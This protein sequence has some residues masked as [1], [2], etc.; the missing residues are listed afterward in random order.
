MVFHRW[1]KVLLWNTVF[2]FYQT[3]T[4]NSSQKLYFALFQQ[5]FSLSICDFATYSTCRLQCYFW[6]VMAFFLQS[7][8]P[9]LFRVLLM[10]LSWTLT[11]T[12]VREV[13]PPKV[14]YALILVWSWLFNHLGDGGIT[15]MLNCFH[16]Y[17][18]CWL[19]F[20]S[21]LNNCFWRSYLFKSIP[22]HILCCKGQTLIRNTQNFVLPIKQDLPTCISDSHGND[23]NAWFKCPL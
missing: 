8:I 18:I 6:R 15:I 1:N 13:H 2:P 21:L 5:P 22:F 20:S 11:F 12:N 10:V 19:N 7:C 17:M 3:R 16:L 14:L 23:W 9:L 4:S